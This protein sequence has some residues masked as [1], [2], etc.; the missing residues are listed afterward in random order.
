MVKTKKALT[1]PRSTLVRTSWL[2]RMLLLLLLV[3]GARPLLD[4][5]FGWHLRSGIDLLRNLSVPKFDSYA[6]TLPNWPWVNHEWLADGLVAFIYQNLGALT[7]ILGF[8]VLIAFI[9][10]LA[11]SLNRVELKYKIIAG[12]I[13]VLAALPIVGVR[14]QVLTLLGMALTMWLIYRYRRG[15]VKHLWWIP[16][17]FL[18]WANLHGG[19]MI[20]LVI[21]ALFFITELAKF[22]LH[23]TRPAIYNKL[24]IV[25]DTLSA[26]KLKH[27]LGISIL[28]G[29]ATLINPYGWGLY[30]DFYKLFINPFAISHISE[31]QPVTV[32]N[33]ISINF[34]IYLAVFVV[35]MFLAYRKVEPTRWVLTLVFLYLSFLYWRNMPFFMVMSV[36]FFAEIIQTHTALVFDNVVRNKT[37]VTIV[38]VVVAVLVAQRIADVVPKA[39][40]ANLNFKAGGYPIDAVNWIKAN[41]DKIGTKMFNEYGQGGFLVWQY[42]E[43]QVFVDGRMPFWV[44]GDKFVFFDNQ[45]ALDAQPGSIE[46]LETKY[47]V[48][49]VII[50]PTRPLD[51]ALSGQATWANVYRDPYAVIYKKL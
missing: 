34:F 50:K 23:Q 17:I 39:L 5:D 8:A 27:L 6:Y 7:L 44:E 49:W 18:A 20:G 9:F 3:A 24:R 33:A 38:T 40:D 21:L 29:L 12:L 35:V 45:L 4:P 10:L 14:M 25:E 37:V 28:S 47:G 42:P 13:A 16:I 41:P 48:D 32:D 19:F 11:A 43:Q 26:R 30:L 1:Q 51:W 46:M 2:E 36:G 22:W 31:W 15:E